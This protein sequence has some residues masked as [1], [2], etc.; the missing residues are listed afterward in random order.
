VDKVAGKVIY[1]LACLSAR[2]LGAQAYAYNC[3]YVGYIETFAFTIDDEQLFCSAAN[4][5]F[6]A[7]VEGEDDWAKIKALMVEA[8]N[9]AMQQTND[10]WAKMWLQWDRDALRV[11]APNADSPETKCLLRK[12]AL[13]TFGS[14]IGWRLTRKAGLGIILF[15]VGYGITLHAVASELYCKG[16]YPEILKPQGEW[17][18]LTLIFIGF[19]LL[20]YQH[21]KWLKCLKI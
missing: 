6:I 19:I 1:T 3:I 7:Y 10:P 8:F 21:F 18:G 20:T 5:G 15:L 11:Y 4:S 13:K 2:K 16:G 14:K 12:A 9:K 17:I